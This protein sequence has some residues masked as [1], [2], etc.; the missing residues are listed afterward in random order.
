M[1]VSLVVLMFVTAPI[2]QSPS[3]L[4]PGET[5]SP[6]PNRRILAP[7]YPSPQSPGAEPPARRIQPDDSRLCDACFVDPQHGWAVGDHGVILHTDDGGRRWSP[8]ASGVN[9]TLNSVSFVDARNGWAAGGMAY[10]YLHDST[11]LVL[12]TRDGGLNWLREPVLLPAL[13]KV[14][15]FDERHG[16][17]IGC[18]SAMF[19]GGVF[20]TRDGGRS[21]QPACSGG[22]PRILTGDFYDSRRAA[23]GGSMGLV[24]T[25]GEGDFSRNPLAEFV[26]P[27]IHA[28]QVVPPRYGWLVGDGG[29]VALTGNRGSSWLPPLSPLPPGAAMFDFSTLAVRGGKCWIAG[30]PGSRVFFTPDAGKTWSSYSTGATVPLTAITFVDDRYGWAVGQLGLVL[31]TSDGGRTWQRQR[32]GG[33]RAAVMAVAGAAEDLPLELLARLCQDQGHLGVAHVLGRIDVQSSPGAATLCLPIAYTRP[34]CSWGDRR[35]KSPGDSP[36]GTPICCFPSRRSWRAGTASIMVT[37]PTPC[38]ATSSGKSAR[39]DPV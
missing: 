7:E 37:A 28:I 16:W 12:T 20:I 24:A 23:L 38:W 29:W 15:F 10:P 22:T 32:S 1:P 4:A 18:P 2:A 3:G 26:L 21:W 35:A 36:S 34:C 31:A 9:C 8:Q 27:D 25:I 19:P 39:G 14:R 11:G 17:A 5:A 13:R 6:R 33:D 30:S